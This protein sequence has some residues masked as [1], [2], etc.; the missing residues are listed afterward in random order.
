MRRRRQMEQRIFFGQHVDIGEVSD[1]HRHEVPVAE[2]RPFRF[3]R[4]SAGVENPRKIVPSSRLSCNAVG[5]NEFGIL[6]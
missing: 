1:R 5:R 2:H 6:L 4:R 3:P